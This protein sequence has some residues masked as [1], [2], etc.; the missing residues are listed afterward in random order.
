MKIALVHDYI[1]EY[2]GAERVLEALHELYPNAPVYTSVYLPKF[3]GP[4]R[5]RFKDWDIRASIVRLFPFKARLISLLRIIAPLLFRSFDFSEYDVVIVSATGAYF[6]NAIRVANNKLQITNDKK[7]VHI[8]YCHTPPRYLYGYATAREWKKNLVVRV[9]GELANHVLR[10][11]DFKAAQNVDFFIANSEEVALRIRKFYRRDSKV[12]YPP[13]NVYARGPVGSFPHPTSSAEK[14]PAGA[15]W[16][17]PASAIPRV[18]YLA[19]GRLARPKHIDLIVKVCTKEKLPLVVFGKDFADYGDE[20]RE[21][22]GSTVTFVGEVSDEE[23]LGLMRRAKAYIFASIDE[24][25]GITPVEAMRVGTP[26]IAYKSGG[27]RETVAEGPSTGSGL[28]TGIFFDSLT[29]D[30]LS[31]AIKQFEKKK[32]DRD[33]IR[34]YAQKFSKERFIKEIKEF[35]QKHA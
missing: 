23:K 11:V 13:V 5:E 15:R 16:G 14:L 17:T 12:I 24:D 2:G 19:G 26:V 10:M 6:P 3:L 4:H 29:E 27:I 25:F 34:K 20:I 7:I 8:T 31:D 32:F 21:M 30:S 18:Y 28:R 1:K 9:L 33:E 22:A 35:V